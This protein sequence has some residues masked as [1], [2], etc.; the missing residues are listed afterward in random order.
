M[1]GAG[2]HAVCLPNQAQGLYAACRNTDDRA[3]TLIELREQEAPMPTLSNLRPAISSGYEASPRREGIT[4]N[5]M[6]RTVAS[7]EFGFNF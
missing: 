6:P 1:R 3:S 2:L 5:A 4:A 7:S